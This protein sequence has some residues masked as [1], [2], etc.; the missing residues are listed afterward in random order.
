MKI[1]M[2]GDETVLLQTLEHT[3]DGRA[4]NMELLAKGVLADELPRL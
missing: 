4:G 1:R 3:A 2:I